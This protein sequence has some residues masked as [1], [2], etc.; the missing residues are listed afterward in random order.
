M[1]EKY[2]SDA[3]Q[4]MI[5]KIF[6]K[7]DNY[8]EI[9]LKTR[10]DLIRHANDFDIEVTN[11]IGDADIIF[12]IGGDGTFLKTARLSDKPIVGINTDTL[13]YLTEVNPDDIRLILKNIIDGEYY[14]E[15]RMMLEGEIIRKDGEIIEIPESLN[16]IAISKNI[17][18]SQV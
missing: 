2:F 15:D 13:G 8:K 7:T 18:S 1:Q 3:V 17:R 6:I 9:A 5:M 10:D 11:E 12:S 16:E 14:I 4:I